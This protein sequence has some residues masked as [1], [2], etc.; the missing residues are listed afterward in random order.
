M[1]PDT[2]KNIIM[3]ILLIV[4]MGCL[5]KAKVSFQQRQQ[6]TPDNAWSPQEQKLRKIGYAIMIVDVIIAGFINV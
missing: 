1:T 6:V 2:I 3:I 4:G 5:M